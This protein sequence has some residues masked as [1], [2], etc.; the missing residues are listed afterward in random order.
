M[1]GFP[2]N[3]QVQARRRK[4]H[5]LKSP[6]PGSSSPTWTLGLQVRASWEILNLPNLKPVYIHPQSSERSQ[7]SMVSPVPDVAKATMVL[8]GVPGLA[9][10][11]WLLSPP[12]SLTSLASLLQSSQVSV[13]ATSGRLCKRGERL[14]GAL[15]VAPVTA[16]QPCPCGRKAATDIGKL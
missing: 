1:T 5:V 11:T 15:W 9:S 16:A 2:L 8:P 12:F 4:E 7:A 10:D 13:P 6:A 3:F 14:L